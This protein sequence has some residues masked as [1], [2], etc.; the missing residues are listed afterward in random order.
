MV[1]KYGRYVAGHCKWKSLPIN[2]VEDERISEERAWE[3][4]EIWPE[5]YVPKT[6]AISGQQREAFMMNVMKIRSVGR[7]AKRFGVPKGILKK[8]FE[9]VM[10]ATSIN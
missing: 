1:D 2:D 7:D 3:D 6:I 5:R 4:W 8:E 10:G 9:K